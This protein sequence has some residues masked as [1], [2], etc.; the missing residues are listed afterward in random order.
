MKKPSLS[1]LE[2]QVSV[3]LPPTK[4]CKIP[5]F[6]K[7][8]LKGSDPPPPAKSDERVLLEQLAKLL[9]VHTTIYVSGYSN[10]I[11]DQTVKELR[12]QLEIAIKDLQDKAKELNKIHDAIYTLARLQG[13]MMYGMLPP[14]YKGF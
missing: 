11:R 1:K 8:L 7:D 12:S 10:E 2:K 3:N 5:S 14:W 9:N 13:P 4:E 6:A